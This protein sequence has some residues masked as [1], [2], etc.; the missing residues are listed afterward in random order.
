VLGVT[1]SALVRAWCV[2]HPLAMCWVVVAT[3]NHWVV[4]LPAGVAVGVLGLL[5]ADRV[6]EVVRVRGRTGP[7]TGSPQ[8]RPGTT[9]PCS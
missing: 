9:R 6:A 2:L 3:G 8:P 4:D 5:V 1:G 7:V